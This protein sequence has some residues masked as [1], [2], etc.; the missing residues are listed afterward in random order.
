MSIASTGWSN[1]SKIRKNVD[2]SAERVDKIDKSVEHVETRRFHR[3][4]RA[5]CRSRRQVRRTRRGKGAPST[6]PGLVSTPSTHRP[7][8]SNKW[9]LIDLSVRTVDSIDTLPK[10]V[11]ESGFFR[12]IA[13]IGRQYR[14]VRDAVPVPAYP[15][16]ARG[17][18][19]ASSFRLHSR[20]P[21]EGRRT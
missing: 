11:D 9:L 8:M 13:S 18:A 1:V 16:K 6:Y 2:I 4:V 5:S 12:Q 3:P 19:G 15:H 17:R 20:S 7:N 21:C 14:H 10:Y